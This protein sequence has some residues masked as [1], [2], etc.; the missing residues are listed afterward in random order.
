VSKIVI[1]TTSEKLMQVNINVP[2]HAPGNVIR[3]KEVDFEV[4][5]VNGQYKAVPLC[6]YQDRTLA[7]LPPELVFDLKDGEVVSSRGNLKDGNLEVINDIVKELKKQ[8][9]ITE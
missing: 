5:K 9:A 4:F 3:Y 7:S 2:F 1:M 8:K 6:S